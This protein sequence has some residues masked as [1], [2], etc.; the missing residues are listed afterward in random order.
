MAPTP[1]STPRP[2]YY[3]FCLTSGEFGEEP[4]IEKEKQQ[5][6]SVKTWETNMEKQQTTELA[7]LVA[8]ILVVVARCLF[9]VA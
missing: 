1:L 4:F 7:V 3:A 8:V 5:L 9:S 6:S 2:V